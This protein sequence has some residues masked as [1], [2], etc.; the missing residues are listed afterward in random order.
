MLPRPTKR[1]SAQPT[2][3][4]SIIITSTQ[5]AA[6]RQEAADGSGVGALQN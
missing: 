6:W 3:S 5:L 1:F 2:T 4:S